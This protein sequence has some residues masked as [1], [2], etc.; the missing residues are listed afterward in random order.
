MTTVY[1]YTNGTN[2]FL[3][4]GYGEGG[5][6]R[7][8]SG[9]FL[10][11]KTMDLKISD[12]IG[13][14]GSVVIT[15]ERG[16]SFGSTPRLKIEVS[17]RHVS[18][19]IKTEIAYINQ[20]I[21]G[22][23]AAGI[24][25]TMDSLSTT[26]LKY[27]IEEQ[28]TEQLPLYSKYKQYETSIFS[29]F[30]F[31]VKYGL[32]PDQTIILNLS[33][34]KGSYPE[35][36]VDHKFEYSHNMVLRILKTPPDEVR[37]TAGLLSVSMNKVP[38]RAPFID[39]KGEVKGKSGESE[40]VWDGFS[41]IRTTLVQRGEGVQLE[42]LNLL[43]YLDKN[44]LAHGLAF[45]FETEYNDSLQAI[46]DTGRDTYNL[47]MTNGNTGYSLYHFYKWQFFSLI[48]GSSSG[49]TFPSNI[50][51]KLDNSFLTKNLDDSSYTRLPFRGLHFKGAKIYQKNLVPVIKGITTTSK[52]EYA[53]NIRDYRTKKPDGT[54]ILTYKNFTSFRYLEL[55]VKSKNGS[56]SIGI[57]SIECPN[58]T[59]QYKIVASSEF[60][61]V[62][63][64][65]CA[66]INKTSLVDIQD[67][68]YPR[69]SITELPFTTDDTQ[70]RINGDYFGI[71]RVYRIVIDNEN[72]EIEYDA[73]NSKYGVNLIRNKTVQYNFLAE[74]LS[75]SNQLKKIY[76][77]QIKDNIITQTFGRRYWQ[78]DTD[79]RNEEE[80]DWGYITVINKS[81]DQKQTS[82]KPVTIKEFTD[83][84]IKYHNGWVVA[85]STSKGERFTRSWYLNS[86]DG[87]MN[88]LGSDGITITAP[89]SYPETENTFS[90]DGY[91]L[92]IWIQRNSD[93]LSR[94]TNII[95][96]TVFDELDGNFVP[97]YHCPFKNYSANIPGDSKSYMYL[98]A[99][100]ILRGRIHGLVL[101]KDTNNYKV[102]SEVKLEYINENQTIDRGKGLSDDQGVFYSRI[103]YGLGL[104]EH[105]VI[106]LSLTLKQIIESA[107]QQRFAFKVRDLVKNQISAIEN[108]L[109]KQLLVAFN[110]S[111]ENVSVLSLDTID[112]PI[113]KIDEIK[114]LNDDQNKLLGTNPF[115]INSNVK[116]N[117]FNNSNSFILAEKKDSIVI[118]AN[119]NSHDTENWYPYT[120]KIDKKDSKILKS[121]VFNSYSISYQSPEIY[122]SYIESSVLK[123]RHVSL[124]LS[125]INEPPT[126]NIIDITE[127]VADDFSPVIVLPSNDVLVIYKLKD[128]A[129]KLYGKLYSNKNLSNQFLILD[130]S[131]FDS[132]PGDIVS[133]SVTVDNDKNL[134][135]MVF[136]YKSS[137]LYVDFEIK[138]ILSRTV[139]SNLKF[140]YVGGKQ[141]ESD[142]KTGK[143]SYYSEENISI[144][145]QRA[146]I[147]S[148][149]RPN[150][151][152]EVIIFFVDDN[153]DINSIVIKPRMST[154]KLRKYNGN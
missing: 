46:L 65:L 28:S 147:V 62:K 138:N 129:K 82:E 95:A 103:P 153:N 151:T 149:T 56:E 140:H 17:G 134:C 146:A 40:T 87:Y 49:D 8:N 3:A 84:L 52:G 130:S 34:E 99:A 93:E 137:L 15:I 54:F 63:I 59:K 139:S 123:I 30:T 61:K 117:S 12:H 85:N 75:G 20:E 80:H 143:V 43:H 128:D 22:I 44:L 86:Y 132:D 112:N 21:S 23:A 26:Y 97:Y 76:T 111:T 32:R 4:E 122:N 81:N 154:S 60:Q 145:S 72:I 9:Q 13:N 66:P 114:Y 109:T 150:K 57:V 24:S 83:S 70:E 16:F 101:D 105:N 42:Q 31:R 125:N 48:A 113:Y 126:A 36:L 45:S 116:N 108:I 79:G 92:N 35:T 106:N 119:L 47:P 11:Q 10:Y 98:T 14:V 71:S 50:K 133:P 91:D 5:F 64:D 58:D 107:K 100:V 120:T 127:N 77:D 124:N 68:P 55:N 131:D 104:K 67:N 118:V 148:S 25:W 1:E 6:A 74:R 69:Y 88:W 33:N 51:M 37:M 18:G 7:D 102:G 144:S 136:Y 73:V 27:D 90:E 53:G 141:K 19:E 152:D 78:S 38:F 39:G 89:G 121:S 110:K 94:S 142:F 41:G 96:Q 135:K 115:L 29:V 2:T